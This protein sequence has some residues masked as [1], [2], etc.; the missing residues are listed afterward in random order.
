MGYLVLQRRVGEEIVLSVKDHVSDA[1]L[2]RQI[3]GDGIRIVV[4]TLRGDCVRLALSAPGSIKILREE[5]VD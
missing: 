1:E 5:L 2:V 3:R 4:S